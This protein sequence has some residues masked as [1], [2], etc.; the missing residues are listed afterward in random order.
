MTAAFFVPGICELVTVS[1]NECIRDGKLSRDC[2][3]LAQ[4][5]VS[6]DCIIVTSFS[7]LHCV[8]S[9]PVEGG[10]MEALC[11]IGSAIKEKGYLSGIERYCS[12][13]SYK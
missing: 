4:S 9:P 7:S 13:A 2:I 5:I 10:K 6:S 11:Q 12:M 8:F 3:F 1:G